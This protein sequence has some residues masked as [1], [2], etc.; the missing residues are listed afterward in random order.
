MKKLKLATKVLL[1]SSCL[2]IIFCFASVAI[3]FQAQSLQATQEMDQLLEQETLSLS[4]LVNST[5]SGK[6]DFEISPLFLSQYR[7][8]NP[9]IFFRFIDPTLGLVLKE[10]T[11]S[12]IVSC[13]INQTDKSLTIA[14]RAYRIHVIQFRPEFDS[15]LHISQNDSGAFVC[16][17]AGISEAPYAAMVRHTLQISVP[18]MVGIFAVLIGVLLILIRGLTRDLSNLAKSL[19]TANFSA[20]HSFPHLPTPNT[21]EVEAIVEKLEAL[22]SQASEVYREMWLFL[23]RAAHQIKTPVTAM[24]S[25]LEV[26]LRKER[27]HNELLLGLE[28]VKSAAV[29]LS[30]LTKKL[31]LSSRI[32]YQHVPVKEKINLEN[33]F[34]ELV[35]LFRSQADENGVQIT[36]ASKIS[37]EVI[38]NHPLMSDIFGNLLE[39]AIIYS[40][41]KKSA[42]ITV[43]WIVTEGSAC[44]EISDQAQGFPKDVVSALF[45]PFVRGDERAVAGSGLGLSI[46]K[47]S[48]HLLGGKIFLRESTSRGSKIV[49][50]L[51]S[52]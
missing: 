18:V 2:L 22:H 9:N 35:G 48:V 44:I 4:A 32:S 33:F 23:G 45:Q 47:K 50:E 13:D 51:P 38:A 6:F 3:L 34:S 52:A 10:S 30:A 39:N 46:A 27:S 41:K 7:Q 25:T 28:D 14:D 12:P 21:P 16:L 20:T 42:Q 15:D 24:R 37:V 1:A 26:L 29:V 11:D 5:K 36:I 8:H 17:I 43:S 40:P 31:I 49:V 19:T